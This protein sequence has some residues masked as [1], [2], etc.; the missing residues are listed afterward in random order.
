MAVRTFFLLGF[1]L[2][3]AIGDARLSGQETL[4][5]PGD[6]RLC[7]LDYGPRDARG[8]LLVSWTN[9]ESYERIELSL[10]GEPA[11][12]DVDGT[13]N[14]ARVPSE[15]G[16]HTVGVRGLVG[17]RA[18]P[19]SAA[20]LTVL[21]ESPIPRPIEGLDCE[22]IPGGVASPGGEAGARLRLTWTLGPDAWV[23]GVLEAPGQE[24][25]VEIPAGALSAEIKL[26]Q[27][28][29]GDAGGTA[30]IARIAF[31]SAAGYFSPPFTPFCIARTPA[32]RRGDADLNGRINITDP[33][34]ALNHLFLGG[35]RWSCD[36]ATDANDD[37]SV[38]LSDAVWMLAYLF[39]GEDPPPAPGPRKCG[40][41]PTPDFLGG[42]CD[43]P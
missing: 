7:Q 4:E 25:T 18:S 20:E 14:A 8:T 22:L 21:G 16:R 24:G 23:S 1:G 26:A 11:P 43:C 3:L 32:F 38:N 2:A 13:F 10:D 5:P 41:D 9:T 37:G 42:I 17:E 30:H 12:G 31:K 34:V 35:T 36:D 33:I 27:P 19:W 40:V 15:P 6:V 39:Q 28:S 29:A